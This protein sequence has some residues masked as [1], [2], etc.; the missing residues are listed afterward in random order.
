[1]FRLTEDKPE[2]VSARIKRAGEAQP[3]WDWVEQSIW[4]ERMLMALEKGVKGGQWYS[5]IDKVTPERTLRLAFQ[6]VAENEGASGV[7]HVTIP[8]F[9]THLDEELRR[10]SEQLRNGTYRPQAIRRHYIPKP[11]S[12]EKRPL[13]IPTIRDRVVQSALRLVLE[14]IFEN[15]FAEHSYGFRPGRGCKDALRR[16]NELIKAGYRYV[17]DADLKSYFDPAS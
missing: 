17:V 5:L 16:V 6:Q 1:M 13:G 4:T 14:P 9:Q 2:A 3:R 7:D 10:L 12:T 8:M 15:E 11:G